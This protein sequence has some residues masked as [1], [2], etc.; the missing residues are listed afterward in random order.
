MATH[1]PFRSWCP[2]CVAG[3]AVISGHHRKHAGP[4]SVPVISIDYAFMG[5]GQVNEEGMSATVHHVAGE[6]QNP[7]IVVED[8]TPQVVS[9]HMV[10]RKG[11]DEHA[12]N[13]I[14]QDIKRLGYR[15]IFFK[16]DQAPAILALNE[17]VS[18]L[19]DQDVIM[20]ASSVG[21]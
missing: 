5:N 7:I 12:V 15:K 9:A 6:G 17:E 18:G 3:K 21:E 13:R 10:P 14:A 19:I 20:Y 16:R 11:N 1:M 2:Y 4:G 8:D